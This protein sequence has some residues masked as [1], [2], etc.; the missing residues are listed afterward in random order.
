MSLVKELSCLHVLIFFHFLHAPLSAL[1]RA[2]ER[3]E[4]GGPEATL[5]VYLK[6][7][8]WKVYGRLYLFLRVGRLTLAKRIRTVLVDTGNMPQESAV[9]DM[10]DA[11]NG[12]YLAMRKEAALMNNEVVS[13]QVD[14]ITALE[15]KQD[16]CEE[17][18]RQAQEYV[19]QWQR[20]LTEV[21]FEH[22]A[23][24]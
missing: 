6:V 4:P 5:A 23:E 13:E 7:D 21:C 22:A 14:T 10:I 17:N 9:Q 1:C 18:F 3:C 2:H 15:S 24:C 8:V 19:Q 12:C 20:S 16:E 11:V